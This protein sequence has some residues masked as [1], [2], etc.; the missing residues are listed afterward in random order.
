MLPITRVCENDRAIGFAHPSPTYRDHTLLVPRKAIPDFP[1]L[2]TSDHFSYL[3]EI[4]EM[5]RQ[6]IDDGGWT[7]YSLGV[8]GGRYQDVAQVHFHLYREVHHWRALTGEVPSESLIEGDG[9]RVFHHPQPAREIHAILQL[10]SGVD[11]VAKACA[12]LDTFHTVLDVYGLAQGGY[13][14]FV[15][16]R[17]SREL[18]LHVVAGEATESHRV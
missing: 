7:D 11:G 8:N 2:L 5:A 15:E 1:A 4:L 9:I 6:V 14:V 3:A 10:P 18:L 16:F 12:T 17:A 13:S